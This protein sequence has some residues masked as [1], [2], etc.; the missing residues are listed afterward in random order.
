M[1]TN[2]HHHFFNFT[3]I[4]VI[5]SLLLVPTGG[6]KAQTEE[7]KP[8]PAMPFEGEPPVGGDIGSSSAMANSPLPIGDL[9]QMGGARLVAT[10][11]G[12]GGWGWELTGPS[13]LNTLGPIAMGLGKAAIHSAD[14][15]Q[16]T[17]LQLAGA[18]L[19]T[20]SGTFSPSDGYLAAELDTAFGGNTYRTYVMTNFYGPLAAGTYYRSAD[21]ATHYTTATYVDRIQTSRHAASHQGN[22]AAWDV[23][24]GLVG[25]AACGADTADWIIGTEDEINLLD[26]SDYYDVIGL[27]GAVYGLA[28]AGVDFDPTAGAHAA[29]SSLANLGATLA[30]YQINASGGFA[31]NSAWVVDNDQDE[32]IQETAYAILALDKLNRAV[33]LPVIQK[34]AGYLKSVQ[35]STGGW[36]NYEITSSVENNEVTGEALWG[37]SAAYPEVWVCTSGD[38]GHPGYG[39]NSIQAGI[40]AVPLGG[41]V[42][43]AAGTYVETGQIVINKDLIIHGA[44]KVTTIIKPAQD[45][46]GSG[47]SGS[48]FLVNDGVTLN[49]S[50][51]TLDG[52]GR[53]IRQAVRFNGNG[54][55]DN[56]IIQNIVAPGYMGFA[57]AQGYDNNTARTL[58]VINSTFLNFGRVGIQ[59]DN[60]TGSST[61]TIANNVLT[62]RGAGDNVSYG[63]TVE[64]GAH[65]TITGNTISNCLGVASS[66]GSTSAAISATTYFAPGT[67]ATITGNTLFNN[68]YG[69]NVGYDGTDTSVVT[70]HH[71]ILYNNTEDGILT[72]NPAILVNA[73]ENWW[74]S[75]SGPSGVGPGTGNSVVSGVTYSPWCIKSDCTATA[76]QVSGSEVLIG[77]GTGPAE[78]QAVIDASLPGTRIDLPAGTYTPAGGFVI[79]TPGL[80]ISLGSGT[81]L[82]PASPCF[83]VNANST[84]ILGGTCTP[85]S[86]DAGIVVGAD[87]SDLLIGSMTIDGTSSVTGSGIVV[88]HNVHNLQIL[89][90]NIH[91]M[92]ADGIT[93][94]SGVTISG[95]HNVYGNKLVN[96]SGLG[97]NNLMVSSLTA[98]N[99]WWGSAAGPASGDGVSTNVDY[100]PWCT[101][102]DCSTLP[103]RMPDT[104]YGYVQYTSAPAVGATVE[105]WVAGVG[106]PFS[107][108]IVDDAGSK[109]YQVE[110]PINTGGASKNGAVEGDIVTFKIGGRIVATAAWHEAASTRLDFHPPEAAFSG[111]PYS[112]TVGAPVTVTAFATH[113]GVDAL[114]YA[115][116]WDNDGTYDATT[117]TASTTHTWAVRGTGTYTIGQKITDAQGGESTVVT[118]TV[119]IGKATATITLGSLNTTYDGTPKAATATT[120]PL[121]LNVTI[122]YDGSPTPPTAAGSYTVFATIVDDNYQGTKT[123]TLVIA[124]FTGSISFINLYTI[125]DGTVK[126]VLATTTPGGLSYT[127]TYDGLPDLPINAGNHAVVATISDPNYSGTVSGIFVIDKANSYVNTDCN[128]TPAV[129]TGLPL[130]PCTGII[131]GAGIITGSL[132][133]NYTNNIDVGTASVTATYAGDPNHTG[134]FATDSFQI[135][136]AAS[137]VTL[138]VTNSPIAY[139]G[140][141]H[142]AQ[143][144]VSVSSVDGTVQNV[145]YDG[146]ATVPTDAKAYT[147]TADFVPTNPNYATLTGQPAGTFTITKINPS[148]TFTITNTPATY[149]GTDKIPAITLGGTPGGH[150]DSISYNGSPNPPSQAGSYTVKA[151]F[152]PTDTTNYNTLVNVTIGTFVINKATPTITLS[153]LT[154]IYDGSPKNIGV[155]TMPINLAAGAIV[156]YDPAGPT[157]PGTYAVTVTINETNYSGSA[158]GTLTILAR[159]GI[160]LEP[161]WNL[162]SFNVHPQDNAISTVLS[163]ISGK[164]DLVY[165]WDKSGSSH[166]SGNWQK[167]AP[168]APAYQNTLAARD[169]RM[170][171]W[172]HMTQAATLNVDGFW[173]TTTSIDLTTNAY[174]NGWNLIGYPKSV[175]VAPATVFASLGANYSLV[176]AYHA[177]DSDHWK[178]YDKSAPAFANDLTLMQ[179]GWGYWIKVS[180]NGT[181]DIAY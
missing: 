147:I 63:I 70:A 148:P 7:Q 8:A 130:T 48:W 152:I 56:V 16:R 77:T 79:N 160:A 123:G 5:L 10:Q 36:R 26:S 149:D 99:N 173:P 161:G 105:A 122:T 156:T 62:C 25:A 42:N 90:N 120:T 167:Y 4:I 142:S 95:L 13:A 27:A 40:T 107:T 89:H 75:A 34:A 88:N 98:E 12:D 139:N 45:T 163:S 81:I 38:C 14:A 51:V 155:S 54:N 177:A 78:I 143:V 178:L 128:T 21:P 100:D 110:V 134:S 39:Y 57:I 176:Y 169:E 44:D 82:H 153:N 72:T 87:V 158:S 31:W 137:T 19:L 35:L 121:G 80:T 30:S 55:V 97:I 73:T 141:P 174:T 108:T 2:H 136:P 132:T 71:N 111:T 15:A 91:D 109:G 24:M 68:S 129:Y 180:A 22:M 1:S 171:I 46:V 11:N 52:V 37:Y 138:V 116:D 17:A 170:G 96:N 166:D 104:Y 101:D 47:D 43:I 179:P 32:A 125:Y 124:P 94:A 164:Y 135:T 50:N 84:S 131:S 126:K 113:A 93:Y 117:P 83:T 103:P 154:Q 150:L 41:I 133:W 65:A 60:G 67:A 145:K 85:S 86:G 119:T 172:I 165:A 28:Y 115:W 102:P 140:L 9:F 3:A 18:L 20:K 151:D 162:V 23:A 59:A 64:G 61:V 159:H 76:S 106:T 58:S 118:T 74:G 175:D 92:D 29:A 66:D 146:S 114:T 49:L 127:I 6:I 181:V 112:G 157:L 144:S 53:N 33:N 69:I 168:W